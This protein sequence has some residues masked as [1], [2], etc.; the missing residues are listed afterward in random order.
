MQITESLILSL[1]SQTSRQ[2][3]AIV[4][5]DFLEQQQQISHG[6]FYSQKDL[7]KKHHFSDLEVQKISDFKSYFFEKQNCFLFVTESFENQKLKFFVFNPI[8][9]KKFSSL[10]AVLD[11]LLVWHYKLNTSNSLVLKDDLTDLYNHR[12]FSR[13][14]EQEIIRSERFQKKF[15]ILFI[16]VDY[17]KKINDTHGHFV[18]S[19]ILK[20]IAAVIKTTIREVD[21]ATRY[22]GDEFVVIALETNPQGAKTLAERIRQNIENHFFIIDATQDTKQQIQLTVSIGVAT[23]PQTA[24]NKDDLLKLA[25]KTMYD[26]KKAGRNKVT[27]FK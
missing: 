4:L 20:Q 17:F 11:N 21:L 27:I 26:S 12:F 3:V 2:G 9:N 15:A 16:D 24:T 13:A 22:G 23:Y 14:L 19:S 10:I 6:D 5:R 1:T 8:D 7:I 18:G 25:D